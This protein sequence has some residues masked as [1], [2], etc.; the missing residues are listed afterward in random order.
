M[1]HELPSPAP[2]RRHAR[3]SRPAFTLVELLVVIGIIAILI[4]ILLP[5]LQKARKQANT[6]QCMSNL[7]QLGLANQM[8]LQENHYI[9]TTIGDGFNPGLY[10]MVPIGKYLQGFTDPYDPA[11]GLYNGPGYGQS[12]KSDAPPGTEAA[13]LYH[14]PPV[15]FC[16]EAPISNVTPYNPAIPGSNM[17]GG[18]WGNAS[19]PWGPGTYHDI[20][21]VA[22][23]YGMNGWLYS[24]RFSPLTGGGLPSPMA[25][26]GLNYYGPGPGPKGTGTPTAASCS[27]MFH[28]VRHIVNATKVPVFADSVWHEAWPCNFGDT[29][30][31]DGNAP[32]PYTDS[33]PTN[34][35]GANAYKSVF[36]VG[37]I[38]GD[39]AMMSKFCI[40]RHGQAINVCFFDGHSETVQLPDLWSLQWSPMSAVGSTPRGLLPK[41]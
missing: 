26:V 18:S 36:N 25:F 11:N 5:A 6:I 39:F 4:G 20:W 35:T 15:W 41:Q 8:Y 9:E 1:C 31:W 29:S 3:G 28:D 19:A 12:A 22:S 14:V 2:A 24:W 16:P 32:N 27:V 30:N 38:N 40:A 33:P 37:S 10:W 13:W 34:L 23:S 7:R 21:Y 17:N